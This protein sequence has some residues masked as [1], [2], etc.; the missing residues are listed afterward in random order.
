MHAATMLQV[1]DSSLPY[2]LCNVS[3]I[4]FMAAEY[5]NTALS[6]LKSVQAL[7]TSL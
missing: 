6:E 7:H 1:W 4:L 2:D 5:N 3:Q